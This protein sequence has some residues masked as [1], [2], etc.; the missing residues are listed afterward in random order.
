MLLLNRNRI[1]KMVAKAS[2]KKSIILNKKPRIILGHRRKKFGFDRLKSF[3]KSGK[4][5]GKGRGKELGKGRKRK[6]KFGL[7]VGMGIGAD[8]DNTDEE[9]KGFIENIKDFITGNNNNTVVVDRQELDYTGQENIQQDTETETDKMI[10]GRDDIL[11]EQYIREP[12]DNIPY[13]TTGINTALV[14]IG[15]QNIYLDTDLNKDLILKLVDML[16]LAG[17]RITNIY[18]ILFSNDLGQQNVKMYSS[19]KFLVPDL[20]IETEKGWSDQSKTEPTFMLLESHLFKKNPSLSKLYSDL[21][22]C[23]KIVIIS[24]LE[25]EQKLFVKEL[26]SAADTFRRHITLTKLPK[27]VILKDLDT[28]LIQQDLDSRIKTIS[29]DR[30][31]YD[32]YWTSDSIK[33]RSRN[34]WTDEPSVQKYADPE[35]TVDNKREARAIINRRARLHNGLAFNFKDGVPIN[36]LGQEY[37]F[38][39]RG[40]LP[41]YGPNFDTYIILSRKNNYDQFGNPVVEILVRTGPSVYAIGK[42]DLIHYLD[43]VDI[44]LNYLYKKLGIML[45]QDKSKLLFEGQLQ[46]DPRNTKNAWVE[47]AVYSWNLT[48]SYREMRLN[49]VDYEWVSVA[50]IKKTIDFKDREEVLNSIEKLNI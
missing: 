11:K 38:S 32:D 9:T 27:I 31:L 36:P 23:N 2:I 34:N 14:I 42:Y 7:D 19:I 25:Q 8:K 33:S 48:N 40:V 17:D 18:N 21:L 13:H 46:N 30:A 15:P 1:K 39:G 26:L 35:I 45:H 37:M 22:G 28:D 29:V 50:D 44:I 5:R 24:F 16:S 49:K 43:N 47:A 10:A 12:F 20:L 41:F 4:G 6:N 3:K